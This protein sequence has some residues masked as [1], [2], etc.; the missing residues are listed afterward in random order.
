MKKLLVFSAL[1]FAI[2]LTGCSLGTPKAEQSQTQPIPVSEQG[3]VQTAPAQ[4]QAVTATPTTKPVAATTVDCGTSVNPSNGTTSY[5]KDLALSCFAKKIV[6][7]C[8]VGKLIIK[9]E[10]YGDDLMTIK[11]QTDGKCIVRIENIYYTDAYRECLID[12]NTV[13]SDRISKEAIDSINMNTLESNV[14][15]IGLL[16]EYILEAIMV[17]EQPLVSSGAS[18]CIIHKHQF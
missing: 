18:N 8:E 2:A 9:D 1:G 14:F 5:A 15:P 4:N 16:T 13:I 3:A 7:K 11:G 17:I 6:N 12:I 10:K